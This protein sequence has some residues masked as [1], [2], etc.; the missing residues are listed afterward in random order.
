MKIRPGFKIIR[1]FKRILKIR[2]LVDFDQ[3]R[4]LAGYVAE[5]FLI[6]RSLS[7]LVLSNQGKKIGV[8]VKRMVQASLVGDK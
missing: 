6:S 8:H 5:G 2:L 3:M 4:S 7:L 1:F